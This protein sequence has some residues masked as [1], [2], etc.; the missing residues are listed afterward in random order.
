M[1]KRKRTILIVAILVL[2]TLMLIPYKSTRS[3]GTRYIAVLYQVVQVYEAH[4]GYH[5]EG[6]R[7]YLV[8]VKV[9]DDTHTINHYEY[10]ISENAEEATEG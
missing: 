3:Y 6:T 1:K 2:L 4:L 5:I 9:F 8:G 10:Q 7:I